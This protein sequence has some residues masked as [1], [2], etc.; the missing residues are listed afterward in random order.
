MSVQGHAAWTEKPFIPTSNPDSTERVNGDIAFVSDRDGS[1]QIYLMDSE[2]RNQYQLTRIKNIGLGGLSW[3]PDG[4]YLAFTLRPSE[5]QGSAIY[6]IRADG[7]ELRRLTS[8]YADHSPSWSSDGK[9]LAYVSARGG[10]Y[11]VWIM[12]HNGIHLW[13]ITN[14][15]RWEMCATWSPDGKY[16]GY[17]PNSGAELSIWLRDWKSGEVLIP[18]LHSA[19]AALHTILDFTWSPDGQRFG[20]LTDFG[21]FTVNT[22]GTGLHQIEDQNT[23]SYGAAPA[24]SPDSSHIVFASKR[25]GKSQIY[26]ADTDGKNTR[27]LTNNSADDFD[28][29]WRP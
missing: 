29:V 13:Q 9:Y 3:S 16:V 10:P 18:F 26:T 2:G 28:P 12:D 24:W 23:A 21:T 25:D 15:P 22:D 19:D 1:E 20:L 27:R 17:V 8:G 7:S 11:D 6:T 5:K 4:Q 14:D